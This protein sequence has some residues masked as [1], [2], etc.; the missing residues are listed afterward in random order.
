MQR[1]IAHFEKDELI[2]KTCRVTDSIKGRET[3]IQHPS[4]NNNKWIIVEEYEDDKEATIDHAKW[5]KIMTAKKLP[6]QL[7]DVSTVE[8]TKLIADN[9]WR[10]NLKLG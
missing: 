7:N 10:K 1:K 5:V 6:L 9:T 4:Y 8:I 3:A 2:V